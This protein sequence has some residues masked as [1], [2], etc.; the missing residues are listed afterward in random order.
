MRDCWL[1]VNA[2]ALQA[3]AEKVRQWMPESRLLAMV[4]ANAY[5]HGAVWASQCLAAQADGFGVATL[6]EALE[7]RAQNIDQPIWVMGGVYLEQEFRQAAAHGLTLIAHSHEQWRRYQAAA[8]AKHPVPVWLKLNTGMN[9]LGVPHEQA[10]SLWQQLQGTPGIVPAG[11]MMHFAQAELPNSAL[12]QL[13]LQRFHQAVAEAHSCTLQTVASSCANSAAILSMPAAQGS[14]MRPGIALYGGSPLPQVSAL[15]LGLQAVMTLRARVI[16]VQSVSAGDSV[17]YGARW[18][19]PH[20]SRI[21][22]L[23]MGYG[24]GYPRHAPD[25]TPVWINGRRCQLAGKVSMDMITVDIGETPVAV[26]D[27]AELWGQHVSVDEVAELC[28]TISYELFCQLT[29]RVRR[30]VANG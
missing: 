9:R 7:L 4:K 12:T 23:S 24:D 5:G 28:G 6:E 3:N 25:G 19:A 22:V 18:T 1:S 8:E 17:G 16:S 20:N 2:K 21:A 10:A 29:P 11:M 15:A 30:E 26:G 14:W 13:Q 27:V